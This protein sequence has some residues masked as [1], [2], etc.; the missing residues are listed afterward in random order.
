V[1]RP[2]QQSS[3]G[4]GGGREPRSEGRDDQSNPDG[5]AEDG[6]ANGRREPDG[7]DHG[8]EGGSDDVLHEPVQDEGVEGPSN[9]VLVDASQIEA[10]PE[11]LATQAREPGRHL[12]DHLVREPGPDLLAGLVEPR[13]E[14]DRDALDRVRQHRSFGPILGV[15]APVG[16]RRGGTSGRPERLAEPECLLPPSA[17]GREAELCRSTVPALGSSWFRTKFITVD[18]PLPHGPLTAIVTGASVI[19]WTM[20]AVMASASG[21]NSRRSA[22]AIRSLRTRASTSGRYSAVVHSPDRQ[23]TTAPSPPPLASSERPST[24]TTVSARTAPK[25]AS[26]E[27]SISSARPLTVALT[28]EG[29]EPVRSLTDAGSEPGD[30]VTRGRCG[31]ASCCPHP[32]GAPAP[33]LRIDSRC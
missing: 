30:E 25:E 14:P 22:S 8:S 5:A 7:R 29:G 6:C 24:S 15:R 9:R 17:L 21:L 28:A 1:H 13:V 19:G 31:A 12:R 33:E 20:A 27:S 10:Q 11:P 26:H 18:L 32:L 23:V 2:S 4:V 3:E 16:G